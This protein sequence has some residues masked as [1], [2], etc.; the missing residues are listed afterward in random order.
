[1]RSIAIPVADRGECAIALNTSF[2]LAKTLGA[3]VVGY[4]VLVE[5]EFLAEISTAQLWAGAGNGFPVWTMASE[6]EVNES[7]KNA[8]TLFL[9]V[10]GNSKYKISK[11]GG[12][13]GDP[14][15]TFKTVSGV[16]PQRLFTSKGALHDLIVVSRPRKGGGQRAHVMMLSALLDSPTPVMILP[17]ENVTVSGKNIVIAWNARQPEAI[18]VHSCLSLL[19]NAKKVT[20][21]TVGKQ[22]G[23]GPSGEDMTT[24]MNAHGIN[25]AAITVKGKKPEKVIESVVEDSNADLLLSG[26]YSRGRMREIIF[27]GVTEYLLSETKLPVIMMHV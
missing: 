7:A 23:K 15:A 17:Q 27:G 18:L 12:K 14:K 10:A 3:D 11:N 2:K 19:K 8:E 24:Y 25:S 6:D 21:M 20:F 4:H 1:M 5:Q 22:E 9:R 16:L 26:A 13:P